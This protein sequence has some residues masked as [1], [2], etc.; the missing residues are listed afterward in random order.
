MELTLPWPLL[1][2]VFCAKHF[3]PVNPG[4]KKP[5]NHGLH[6]LHGKKKAMDRD[7]F[8]RDPPRCSSFL[9]VEFFTE[10]A[11]TMR[12]RHA[13]SYERSG[14]MTSCVKNLNDSC[15]SHVQRQRDASL[16]SVKNRKICLKGHKE[17]KE[18]KVML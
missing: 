8:L 6:G 7:I 2:N 17:R 11:K 12:Q 5:R 14:V 15:L 10:V 3:A 16:R 18:K 1:S 9:R 4:D 13:E